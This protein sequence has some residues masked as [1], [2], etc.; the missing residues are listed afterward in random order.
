MDVE[1][2]V[3]GVP[4]G[5]DYYGVSEERNNAELFYDNSGESIKYVIETKKTGDNAYVYYTYLRYKGIVGFGGRPGSYFGLTLRIDKYYLDV[6]HVYNML[7]MV[8]KKYVVGVFL[9]FSGDSYKYLTSSFASKK[10]EIDQ[11]QQGLIQLIQGTCISSKFVNID[12]SFI[13]P[14]TSAASCNIADITEN[15]MLA[16]IKKYSKVVLSPDYKL[17]I[18]KEYEK[19]IQEA[20][21]RGGSLVAEKDK[22]LV[23]KDGTISSLNATLSSQKSKIEVLQAEVKQKESEISQLKKSGNLS[24]MISGIKDPIN[25]LAE[26]FRVSDSH[27]NSS[28]P[29]YGR[30]IYLICIVSCFLS[31]IVVL[32]S[33][34]SM[35]KPS[36]E[37]S[38]KDQLS[39]MTSKIDSL[40]KENGE[41][42]TKI[43]E[44]D[45]TIT[46]QATQISAVSDG[47][48]GNNNSAS[49]QLRIDIDPYSSGPL[50]CGNKYTIKVVE[51]TSKKDY[52]GKGSW[53][54][55]NADI[56]S[57][58]SNDP[59]IVIKPK[60]VG[61]VKISYSSENCICDPREFNAKKQTSERGK[62]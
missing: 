36:L 28:E 50:Y 13:H 51:K 38:G 19:K 37:S 30:K 6:V 8:F 41:L 7:E 12:A 23:E 59:Q 43:T 57:G 42:R 61:E 39:I 56:D 27:K 52:S 25:S 21:G 31:A 2:L 60:N 26:Y 17:N 3:H 22:K 35:S 29:S 62:P 4:D 1:I 47:Q 40:K 34:Y 33:V 45:N 32:L 48:A 18:V 53:K 16:S 20:E 46:Y 55:E 14:I 44:K 9:S 10:T 58:S 49:Q 5:Q 15:A 11:L 24:Q 54:L